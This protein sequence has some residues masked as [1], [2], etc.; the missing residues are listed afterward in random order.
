VV[1]CPAVSS[2]LLIRHAQA[3]FGAVDYDVLS[4]RGGEQARVLGEHLARRGPR[5]D[6]LY[7][8]PKAR[9]RDT[10]RHMVEAARAGGAELPEPQVLEE[11]DEYPAFELY[12]HWLPT[13][14]REEPELATPGELTA[15]GA[16]AGSVER[17]VKRVADRWADGELETDHIE[18]YAQF[19][20]R[21][22]RGLAR[23][24]AEQGRRRRVGLVTS[25]GPISV[26]LRHTLELSPRNAMKLAWVIANTSITELRYREREVG[27]ISFN[28]TPH[29]D[30]EE[31]LL[32]YR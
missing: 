25:G 23:V 27:L 22:V 31:R 29:F 13:L 4:E 18:S 24:M 11:L 3:S 2:L 19:C 21:V 5:L 17:A 14:S 10:A 30:G 6:A 32:T 20:E 28:A 16:A 15:T 26:A 12:R 9:H 1:C 8:G 7:S